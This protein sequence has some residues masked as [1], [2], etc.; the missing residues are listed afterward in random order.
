MIR[1]RC[2]A[3][4]ARMIPQLVLIENAE[5]RVPPLPLVRGKALFKDFGDERMMKPVGAVRFE[6]QDSSLCCGPEQLGHHALNGVHGGNRFKVAARDGPAS[7]CKDSGQVPHLLRK[8]P[9]RPQDCLPEVHRETRRQLGG[10]GCQPL[11]QQEVEVG[12]PAT[13]PEYFGYQGLAGGRAQQLPKLRFR[14]WPVQ[15]RQCAE[16]DPWQPAEVGQPGVQGVGFAQFSCAERTHQAKTPVGRAGS[17]VHQHIQAVLI[18]PLQVVNDQKYGLFVRNGADPFVDA[19]GGIGQRDM[20]CRGEQR[21]GQ[22][23]RCRTQT[24]VGHFLPC[25]GQGSA[26]DDHHIGTRRARLLH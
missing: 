22:G 16:P 23:R 17:Q 26:F 12:I 3:V 4:P 9:P 21:S 2:Q 19:Q 5:S 7:H 11:G 6:V 15:R 8:A 10:T 1:Q 24:Q 13:V 14:A 25:K 18:D 20:G